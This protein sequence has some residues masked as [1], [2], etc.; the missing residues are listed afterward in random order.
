MLVHNSGLNFRKKVLMNWIKA[1]NEIKKAQENNRLVVFVG[2]GVSK[3]SNMPSWGELVAQIAE[4][5]G[6]KAEIP[7]YLKSLGYDTNLETIENW[8]TQDE[9]LRIPEYFYQIDKS[10]DHRDYYQL[11]KE[12]LSSS[13]SSNPI[14]SEIFNMLPH[15]II[16][17]NYDSLLEKAAN[18]LSQLYTVVSEDKELLSKPS[19]RY[20]IKMHGDIDIPKSIVLN[21]TF[22][23]SE[24]I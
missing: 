14:D 10:T 22:P 7:S 12:A 19:D 15:H 9:Y 2:A 23:T 16:T 5:I 17:T 3:N 6:Y 24:T 20:I 18:P 21:I 8:F 13:C 4:K 11:I 1:V